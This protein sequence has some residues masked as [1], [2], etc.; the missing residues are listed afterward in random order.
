MPYSTALWLLNEEPQDI[1][2]PQV[3][4]IY[5]VLRCILPK[6]CSSSAGCCSAESIPSSAM[7][8]SNHCLCQ[9][10]LPNVTFLT[11]VISQQTGNWSFSQTKMSLIIPNWDA[12][13]KYCIFIQTSHCLIVFSLSAN[14][15]LLK[16]PHVTS[17]VVMHYFRLYLS[18]CIRVSQA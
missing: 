12:S 11:L 1:W 15:F 4:E 17:H 2:W 6:H 13:W 9:A 10:A 8:A 14:C 5:D 7:P 16:F 3:A 18:C